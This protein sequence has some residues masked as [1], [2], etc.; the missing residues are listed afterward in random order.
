M[1]AFRARSDQKLSAHRSGC[2]LTP[3]R[4]V[5]GDRKTEIEDMTNRN[6]LEMW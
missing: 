5:G 6:E 1:L 2:V 3:T 4:A